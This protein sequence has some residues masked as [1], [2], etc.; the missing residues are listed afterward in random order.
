L[1]LTAFGARDRW[2]F[3]SFCGAPRRQLKRNTLGHAIIVVPIRYTSRGT[4]MPTE[5]FRLSP[6][7][8]S[9]GIEAIHPAHLVWERGCAGSFLGFVAS[10]LSI[11][12]ILSYLAT[13]LP[14]PLN[15]WLAICLGGVI[16]SAFQGVFIRK[17]IPVA[18]IWLLMSTLSWAGVGLSLVWLLRLPTIVPSLCVVVLA[19]GIVSIGQYILIRERVPSAWQWMLMNT[20]LGGLLWSVPL[21]IAGVTN[22]RLGAP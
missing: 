6:A 11:G 1:Q 15:F 7:L 21:V 16:S 22:Y 4:I 20:I 10:P 8:A 13:L 3:G 9:P 5:P 19:N 17:A 14:Y 18:W 12:V 2:H